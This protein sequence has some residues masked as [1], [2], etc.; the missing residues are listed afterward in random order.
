MK[1]KEEKKR[2]DNLWSELKEGKIMKG[3]RVKRVEQ[4]EKQ[5]EEEEQEGRKLVANQ[6]IE[7][8]QETESREINTKE[9][10]NELQVISFKESG[11]KVGK[12]ERNFPHRNNEDNDANG[13]EGQFRM[14]KSA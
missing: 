6:G 14:S 5:N 11:P 3:P 1:Y 12:E 2:L 4:I 13:E 10:A 7:A 9:L 8:G